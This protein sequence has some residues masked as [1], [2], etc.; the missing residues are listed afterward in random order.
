VKDA[1]ETARQRVEDAI[2]FARQSAE[3]DPAT[4][5]DHVFA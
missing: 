2:A 5:L 4:A 3:P 1:Q